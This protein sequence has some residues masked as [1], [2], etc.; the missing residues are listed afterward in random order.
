MVWSVLSWIVCGFVIGLIARAIVPGRQ[1][2]G[3]VMT[4]ILGIVGAF[5]GG[6]I[7]SLIWGAPPEG[8]PDVS[9][10]WPGWLFS[11]IGATLLLWAYVALAGRSDDTAVPSLR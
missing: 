4:V 11:I 6:L 3:F 7:A 8:N 2:I 9:R 5:V 10:M 1:S